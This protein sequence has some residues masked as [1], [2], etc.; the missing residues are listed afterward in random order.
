MLGHQ[1]SQHL[2]LGVDLL[3][4]ELDPL[5]FTLAVRPALALEGGRAI[6]EE[7]FLPAV[8]HRRLQSMLLTKI[9]NRHFIQ[10]VP[11]QDGN[12]LFSGVVLSPFSHTSSP[13][14]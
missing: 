12:L 7:L 1:F 8:E 10:Q 13:L 4:Q 14:S 11:S 2:V 3:F 5:L 9:R 6:L